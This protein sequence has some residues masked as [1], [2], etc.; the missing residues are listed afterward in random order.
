MFPLNKILHWIYFMHKLTWLCW[1]NLEKNCMYMNL[2]PLCLFQKTTIILIFKK[3]KAFYSQT[4]QY[5]G[6]EFTV[7]E[8]MTSAGS[9]A[10]L[11]VIACHF[12]FTRQVFVTKGTGKTVEM[13]FVNV[14]GK[15]VVS[16]E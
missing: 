5:Y 4:L 6:L 15:S 2:F 14:S 7:T 13:L 12:I 16:H 10:H 3:L 11:V 9:R 1:T 8:R